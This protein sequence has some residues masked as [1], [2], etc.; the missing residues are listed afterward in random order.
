A[1]SAAR[2]AAVYRNVLDRLHGHPAVHRVE[3]KGRAVLVAIGEAAE[4]YNRLGPAVWKASVI[5]PPPPPI[6]PGSPSLHAEARPASDAL[7]RRLA[8]AD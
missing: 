3:L 8:A 7:A 6:S 4:H 1:D 2:F 5:T